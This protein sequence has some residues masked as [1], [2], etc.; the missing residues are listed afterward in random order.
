MLTITRKEKESVIL[1]VG[2]EK[3]EVIVVAS[4]SDHSVRL[5]FNA[6]DNVTIIRTEL[7]DKE[8]NDNKNNKEN[9]DNK[10]NK[11]NNDNKNDDNKNKE[12]LK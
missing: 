2:E 1:E 4:R 5:A 3:I 11:E 7:L 6:S 12:N 10:N 9:N 8:N